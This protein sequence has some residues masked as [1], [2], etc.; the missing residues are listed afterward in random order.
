MEKLCCQGKSGGCL[1]KLLRL[2]WT[3][4]LS[5]WTSSDY[6]HMLQAHL[7]NSFDYV[8]FLLKILGA[9]QGSPARTLRTTGLVSQDLIT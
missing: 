3:S 9:P 6:R 2:A 8:K 5:L 1:A 4:C 7:G